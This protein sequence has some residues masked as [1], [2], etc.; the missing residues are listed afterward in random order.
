MSPEWDGTRLWI[1]E[2]SRRNQST[3]VSAVFSNVKWRLDDLEVDRRQ[4]VNA[5][6]ANTKL[7]PTQFS[8]PSHTADSEMH[9]S[10]LGDAR[11]PKRSLPAQWG[12]QRVADLGLKSHSSLS[13]I[14]DSVAP[15]T[16]MHWVQDLHLITETSQRLSMASG[17]GKPS[18]QLESYDIWHAN[19]VY[20]TS[21]SLVEH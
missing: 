11:H 4:T 9:P 21:C 14:C 19:P 5:W 1:M 3:N 15:K 7:H 6:K 8:F 20:W 12:T 17:S 18:L 16:P 10:S 2:D 13:R